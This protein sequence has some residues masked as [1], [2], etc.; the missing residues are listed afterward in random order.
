MPL[1]WE[2][3]ATCM[4]VKNLKTIIM[5]KKFYPFLILT[6]FF[7]QSILSQTL[8]IATGGQT[9]TSGVGWAISGQN[10]VVSADAIIAPS[11]IE[12]AL[13]SN[14]LNIVPSVTSPYNLNVVVSN[15][16]NSSTAN[17]YLLLQPHLMAVTLM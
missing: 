7:A 13:A 16:I 17:R 10:L 9:G 12:T 3:H 6:L 8:T 15:A 1:F 2:L 4:F 14:N 5:K 11:V